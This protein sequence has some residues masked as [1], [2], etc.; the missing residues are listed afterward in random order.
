MYAAPEVLM[1]AQA[2]EANILATEALDAWSVGILAI[3]MFSGRIPFDLNRQR[4]AVRVLIPCLC[5][6]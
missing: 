5:Q 6:N 2:G 1:A 3:Q 4:S